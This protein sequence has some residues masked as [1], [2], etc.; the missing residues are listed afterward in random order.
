MALPDGLR[1]GLAPLTCFPPPHHSANM[2]AHLGLTTPGGQSVTMVSIKYFFDTLLPPLHPA[3]D[4]RRTVNKLKRMGT[5]SRRPITKHN[6]WWGFNIDPV[7]RTAVIDATSFKHM[8]DVARD[9]VRAGAVHGQE[10]SLSFHNNPQPMFY[11][12]RDDVSLPDAYL[13]LTSVPETRSTWEQIAVSGE[14]DVGR[15]HEKEVS[16]HVLTMSTEMMYLS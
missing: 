15:W 4:I 7:E 10:P 9:I 11:R 8:A 5:K 2:A 1:C 14:Y 16:E 3:M 13:V 6:R 12:G